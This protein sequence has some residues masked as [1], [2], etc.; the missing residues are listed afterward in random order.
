MWGKC[1][2]R[3]CIYSCYCENTIPLNVGFEVAYA[4]HSHLKY[5]RSQLFPIDG[6]QIGGAACVCGVRARVWCALV[7][8]P[9]TTPLRWS[10]HVAMWSIQG[11]CALY[12]LFMKGITYSSRIRPS[13]RWAVVSRFCSYVTDYNC[14]AWPYNFDS[15]RVE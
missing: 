13:R 10:L 14:D 7:V 11:V 1:G 6:A 15:S 8:W 12:R 5:P 2:A 9:G 4:P 3:L